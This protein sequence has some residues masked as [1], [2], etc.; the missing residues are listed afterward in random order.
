MGR[1]HTDKRTVADAELAR[2]YFQQAVDR[3]GNYAPAYAGMSNAYSALYLL[4]GL[5]SRD[6]MPKAKEAA[7][8]GLKI[9]DTLSELHSA[10]DT[11]KQLYDWDWT[12][13]E[14]EFRRALDLG[15]KVDLSQRADEELFAQT[16]CTSRLAACPHK[17]K[18]LINYVVG[19]QQ[20]FRVLT[21]PM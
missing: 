2:D 9:D 16:N 21:Q 19:C 8:T 11:V 15:Q 7:L 18:G 1:Y 12:G 3:D 17:R 20:R 5:P 10:L 14:R 6:A 13:A 4:G